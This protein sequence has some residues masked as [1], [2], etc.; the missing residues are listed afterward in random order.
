M[1]GFSCH[2]AAAHLDNGVSARRRLD[3]AAAALRLVVGPVVRPGLHLQLQLALLKLGG[4]GPV[5]R[6][7]RRRDPAEVADKPTL[8]S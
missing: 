5:Q 7:G 1:T 4:E 6:G 2:Q 3:G 8:M